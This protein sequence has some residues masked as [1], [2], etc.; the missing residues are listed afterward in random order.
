MGELRSALESSPPFIGDLK[1]ASE[2]DLPTLV[3]VRTHT[4][5]RGL[6]YAL[7]ADPDSGRVGQLTVRSVRRLHREGTW[8]RAFVVG[9]P[10]RWEWHRLDSGLSPDMHILAL[11]ATDAQTSRRMLE[12]IHESRRRWG[13]LDGRSHVWRELVSDVLPATP[14]DDQTDAPHSVSMTE[15]EKMDVARDPFAPFESL[16]LSSPFVLGDEGVEDV[17]AEEGENG[18]WFASVLAVDI[19]TE[20]GKITL[21]RARMVEV[22]KGNRILDRRAD[23][24]EPGMFLLV[25]RREGR[26]GLLEALAERLQ[27]ARP[28]LIAAGLMV[29]DLQTVV[30]R[31]FRDSQFSVTQLHEVL[32]TLGF[33]KT[34]QAVRG[35]VG[36]G[37]P[38]APRDIADVRRLNEALSLG[39]A[40]SRI[41]T[42]FAAVQKLR[43]FKRAAGRALATAARGSTVQSDVSRVDRETGLSMADLREVVVE[44]KILSVSNRAE[45]VP[46]T[47]IGHMEGQP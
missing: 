29:S 36:K 14:G 30:Q 12:S 19:N 28:D 32:G 8:R 6:L 15:A 3:V 2:E 39:L 33:E 22:R 13:S 7:G 23:I 40:P 41:N 20:I 27:K 17:V 46:L 21:P 42:I 38:L 26:L 34:Y 35:Y 5:A 1:A 18:Q 43:N 4:A 11:G 47:E 9:L 10:A 24:L 25:G 37:G 44:A 31:G 16:V 45:P